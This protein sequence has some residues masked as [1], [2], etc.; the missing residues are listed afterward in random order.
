MAILARLGVVLGLDSAEFQQGLASAGKKLEAFAN[1][2]GTLGK[3][4][5]LAFAAMAYEAGK[6]ADELSD[7]A[8]ANDVTIASVLK[9]Q[10]ALMLSGGEAGNAGKMLNSF[11]NFID[12]AASGNEDAQK[13]FSKMGISLKDLAN[14][15]TEDLFKKYV[16]NLSKVEDTATRA[17]KA[18]DA[19]GKSGKGVDFKNFNDELEKGS[20]LTAEYEKSISDAADAWDML[21]KAHHQVVTNFAGGMGTVLK[22]TLEYMEKI[23]DKTD[24]FGAAA[25]TV[26]QTLAVVGSNLEFVYRGIADEIQHTIDNMVVLYE[27]P[28]GQKIEAAKSANETYAVMREKARAEL[29]AFQNSVMHGTYVEP[30][31]S[32]DSKDS[33]GPKRQVE[34]T[35]SAQKLQQMLDVAKLI[36]EEYKRHLEF[37]LGNLKT[38]GQ[39]LL[40]TDNQKKVQ[41]EIN[42]VTDDADKKLSEIAKKRE[43]ASAHDANQRIIDEL[44]NQRIE[45]MLLRDAY[46][47]L[48]RTEIES[49]IETQRTFE[50][51]WQ[52]AFAQYEEDSRNAAMLADQMFSSVTGN[53][54]AAIDN[55]VR[56]GKFSFK[57]FTRSIIQDLIAIQMKMQAMQMFSMALN[58]FGF[59]SKFTPGSASFVGPM[60]KAA[61]GGLINGPT[62]V[63]ENGPEIFIPQSSGTVIPNQRLSSSMGN[64]PQVV[65]NGPYIANMSA[66]DTQSATQFL[67]KNKQT[68][69]AANQSAQR[70]LP[71]SR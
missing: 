31:Q 21:A 1:T 68:I 52:K 9:L 40:M 50:F 45:V 3:T 15:S 26:F 44:D 8:K 27:T 12:K 69:W 39:M 36:S 11:S 48:T 35:K 63:G 62:L 4:G 64:Q 6:L 13:T 61:D 51:G 66:I 46:V 38:Q 43:E 29:D 37:N 54:S 30:N 41:E 53:M 23:S 2:A 47:E 28:W 17:A 19:F 49:Q 32:P 34:A 42:K 57:D 10:H 14:L 55:F 24:I 20:G 59:G 22:E 70:S 16:D 18:N 71:A 25:K 56:T 5:A 67:T 60:P 58:A 65:Y 33:K 7:T